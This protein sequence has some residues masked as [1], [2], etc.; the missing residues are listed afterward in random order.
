MLLNL[1]KVLWVDNRKILKRSI[2]LTGVYPFRKKQQTS[3]MSFCPGLSFWYPT[4]R[5]M[6]LKW[7]TGKMTVCFQFVCRYV[8]TPPLPFIRSVLSS[9]TNLSLKLKSLT[10]SSYSWV[11]REDPWYIPLLYTSIYYIS[12]NELLKD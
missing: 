9:F 3:L 8:K 1:I 6:T 12:G 7:W 4:Y 5:V 10:N 2:P 11:K